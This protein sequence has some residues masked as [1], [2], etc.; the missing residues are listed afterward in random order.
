MRVRRYT[1]SW[2]GERGPARGEEAGR[3]KVPPGRA[4]TDLQADFFARRH[5][6]ALERD[7]FEF[8]N[9]SE[10]LGVFGN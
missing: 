10:V 4:K 1:G 2:E 3:G 7:G 8:L 5:V 9:F 6:G